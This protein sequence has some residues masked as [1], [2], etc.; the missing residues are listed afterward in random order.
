MSS[1]ITLLVNGASYQMTDRA[2]VSDVVALL[3][4][5]GQRIAVEVNGEVV[6]RSQHSVFAL[7]DQD[8]LEVVQAIG[9][10]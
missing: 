7:H 8:R 9:G 3:S 6:P 4:L 2:C 5:S 1:V 10:G